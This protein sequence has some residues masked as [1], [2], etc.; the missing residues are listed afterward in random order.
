LSPHTKKIVARTKAKEASKLND[1]ER[2]KQ[3]KTVA[4]ID[5]LVQAGADAKKAADKQVK[6]GRLRKKDV[7]KYVQQQTQK[8]AKAGMKER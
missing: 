7:A 6:A 3:M 2:W 8:L 5:V 1:K 4:R